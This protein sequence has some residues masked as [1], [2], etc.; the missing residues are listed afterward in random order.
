MLLCFQGPAGCSRQ[1]HDPDT[2]CV[3]PHDWWWVSCVGPCHTE[4]PHSREGGGQC[5][6][7]FRTCAAGCGQ[8]EDPC[9]DLKGLW[10]SEAPPMR[11]SVL[12]SGWH[13]HGLGTS[14]GHGQK[15]LQEGVF[16]PRLHGRSLCGFPRAEPL[17]VGGRG[18]SSHQF[19]TNQQR[20]VSAHLGRLLCHLLAFPYPHRWQGWIRIWRQRHLGGVGRVKANGQPRPMGEAC[21]IPH[22]QQLGL[23]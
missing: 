1:L 6:T 15:H 14:A 21:Y 11:C 10:W 16:P 2:G 3:G 7:C 19:G 18:W 20:G 13:T 22:Q 9:S 8:D 12:L 17:L 4:H 5:C 23:F